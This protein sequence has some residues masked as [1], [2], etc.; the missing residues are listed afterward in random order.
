MD[1]D[2]ISSNIDEVLSINPPANVF[3]FGVFSNNHKDCLTYSGGTD[4]L[5]NSYNLVI[6]N[7]LIQMAN[8][9]TR[10]LVCDSHSSGLLDFFLSSNASIYS[11]V[12]FP[13]LV[14]F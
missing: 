6:S 1:F 11:T 9:P 13:P 10:I 5:V 2:S 12:A 3:F 7:N 4:R 8:F 14:N